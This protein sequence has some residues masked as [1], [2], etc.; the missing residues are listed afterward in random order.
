MKYTLLFLIVFIPSSV[1]AQRVQLIDSQKALSRSAVLSDSGK[2]DLAIK[3]LLTIPSRDTNYVFAQTKLAE[4]YKNNNQF[5]K[6]IEIADRLLG[7]KTSY[8]AEMICTKASAYDKKKEYDKAIA[9]LQEGLKKYPFD[10]QIRFQ[11][12]TAY[13]NK[14]DYANAIKAYYDVLEIYPYSS[15]T[16]LNLG[17]I[18]VW[19]GDKTHAMLSFGMYLSLKETDN[20]KLSFFENLVSNQLDEEGKGNATKTGKNAFERLDQILQSKIAMDKKFKTEVPVDAATV[21]Q[22]EMLF[23]QLNTASQGDDDPWYKFY[24]PIYAAIRDKKMITPFLNHILSSSSI[25]SVQKWNSK[26]EKAREAFFT[27]VREQLTRDRGTIR[28]PESFELGKTTHAEYSDDNRVQAIGSVTK[29]Q[30]QG[31]Y[32]YYHSNGVRS[33]EGFYDEGKKVKTWSYW[34]DNGTLSSMESYNDSI[35]YGFYNDEKKKY[36]YKAKNEDINGP[37]TFYYRSGIKSEERIHHDGKRDGKGHWYYENG[38]VKAEFEYANDNTVGPWIDYEMNGKVKARTPYKDGEIDG[39]REVFWPDGKL[40][41]RETYVAGKRDGPAEFFHDN[42]KLHYKGLYKND[43]PVGE[44]LYYTRNGQLD[45]SRLFN[46]AGKIDGENPVYFEGVLFCK[47]INKNGVLI[48][49]AYF[50]KDGKEYSKSGSPDGT[51][52]VKHYYASGQLLWE[53][54]YKAGFRDGKW[55]QY[56]REGNVMTT[57]NYLDGDFNGEQTDFYRN[58]KKRVVSTYNKGARNGYV[59]EFYSNGQLSREGWYV[60]GQ[61]QQQWID[62]F[63]DGSIANDYYYLNDNIVDTAYTYSVEGKIDSRDFYENGEQIAPKKDSLRVRYFPDGKVF[64]KLKFIA[65]EP[66]GKYELFDEFGAPST[67]GNYINGVRYGTWNFV[68]ELGKPDQSAHY[69]NGTADSTLVNYYEFGSVFNTVQYEAGDRNGLV[70]FFAPNGQPIVEK[71]YTDDELI[72]FRVSEKN[73]QFGEWRPISAKFS[74]VAYYA[75]GQKAYEEEYISGTISG[76]KRIY[77]PDGK[78]CKDYSYVDGEIDGPIIDYYPNGKVCMKG[79]F[80]IGSREGVFEFFQENGMPFKTIN[81]KFGRKSGP[82]TLYVKGV[83]SKE[84]LYSNDLPVR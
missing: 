44:W 63:P 3:E 48:Q 46:D 62:Y 28:V 5:D 68:N 73:G 41:E 74:V 82:T 84:V 56:Y 70:K 64:S 81:Y 8:A 22:F 49:V 20:A 71:K 18:A 77:F 65:G 7:W 24:V 39:V 61:M 9:I 31:R 55:T 72:A 2:L 40:K 50:D 30:E 25:A 58:G 83:K 78:P 15:A 42:G 19:F 6:A 17:N 47:N 37:I 53:G 75:N 45:E 32:F 14:H 76:Q 33:A 43:L 52:A 26:N 59:Q 4:M 57:Y 54:Q 79:Q 23:Q 69:M 80:R 1:L 27:V 66:S 21:R 51:F 35:V 38:N 16:H 12:G 29:G 60:D 10:I 67:S 36:R 13:H 34:R 11:I